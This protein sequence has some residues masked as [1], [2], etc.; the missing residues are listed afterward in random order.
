MISVACGHHVGSFGAEPVWPGSLNAQCSGAWTPVQGHEQW[1]A[2]LPTSR[3]PMGT[4]GPAPLEEGPAAAGWG[5]LGPGA[6]SHLS[7]LSELEFWGRAREAAFLLHPPI[8]GSPQ[9]HSWKPNFLACAVPLPTPSSSA[10]SQGLS[11][12]GVWGIVDVT[13]EVWMVNWALLGH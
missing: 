13:A 11:V 5:L 9:G 1:E 7:R 6:V 8:G 10:T 2:G 3:P 4:L 12:G